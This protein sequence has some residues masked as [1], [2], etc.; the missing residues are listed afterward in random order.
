MLQV[1]MGIEFL[2]EESSRLWV[3]MGIVFVDAC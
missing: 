1:I 2:D 3:V